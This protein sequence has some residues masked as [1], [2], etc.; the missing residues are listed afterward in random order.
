[1]SAERPWKDNWETLE[2]LDSSSGQGFTNLVKR[3]LEPHEK[4][5]LKVLKRHNDA[6]ARGR[7]KVEVATLEQIRLLDGNVPAVIEHNTE[8]A[9]ERDVRLYVVMEF[10]DGPTLENYVSANGPLSLA[11]SMAITRS[12]MR[13]I[14]KGHEG[15]I[16]HRDIKPKNLIL[17]ET[18]KSVTVLDYGISFN[19]ELGEELTRS[20]EDFRNE[21]IILP[22]T[23]TPGENHRDVRSDIACIAGIL[24]FCLT[25]H[26]P[27]LIGVAPPHRRSEFST[28][29]VLKKDHRAA[30]LDE[31]LDR[32]LCR[33]DSRIG[34]VS[35]LR[36]R[37]DAVLSTSEAPPSNLLESLKDLSRSIKQRDRKTHL[38]QMKATAEQ[39]AKWISEYVNELIKSS[40]GEMITLQWSGIKAAPDTPHHKLLAKAP[41]VTVGLQNYQ[42]Q[43]IIAYTFVASGDTMLVFRSFGTT[44]GQKPVKFQPNHE[45]A[46]CLRGESINFA[47]VKQDLDEQLQLAFGWIRTMFEQS[48]PQP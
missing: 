16:L 28:A 35:E 32:A 42:F 44:P 15:G 11:D 25:G 24:Y 4:A 37:L 10:I 23:N 33:V 14:S 38:Q 17:N 26:R 46:S 41:G 36:K 22:E 40:K 20:T 19:A 3:K 48:N 12:L 27:G 8:K 30:K 5:V 18:D 43:A 7:M 45:I 9:K 6:Q 29:A 31:V 13:T 1:M 21:F 47:A 2:Q 34:D 39:T